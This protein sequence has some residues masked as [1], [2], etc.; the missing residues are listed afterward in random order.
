MNRMNNKFFKVK[1]VALTATIMAF[2]WQV[3]QCFG[4]GN[5]M[6][7]K[8]TLNEWFQGNLKYV[9]KIS[10]FD[11][12]A[13]LDG[14]VKGVG[15]RSIAKAGGASQ[16]PVR[17]VKGDGCL[18]IMLDAQTPA[19]AEVFL[20]FPATLDMT[21]ASS[22]SFAVLAPRRIPNVEQYY[23]TVTASDGS[24]NFSR[25]MIYEPGAWNTLVVNF[26]D[27]PFKNSIRSF[28]FTFGIDSRVAAFW[29]SAAIYLDEVYAGKIFD[30]NFAADG[31]TQGF[32]ASGGTLSARN[33]CLEL[34][35]TGRNASIVSPVSVYNKQFV[36]FYGPPGVRNTIYIVMKN[37]TDARQMTVSF[38]NAHGVYAGHKTI[39]IEPNASDFAL[40]KVNFSEH[41]QWD[42]RIRQFKIAFPAAV[43]AGN[44]LID[45]IS[46]EEDEEIYPYAGKVTSVKYD[47]AQGSISVDGY[48]SESVLKA[49]TGGKIAFYALYLNDADESVQTAKPLHTVDLSTLSATAGKAGFSVG[50]IKF[51]KDA[52]KTYLDADVLAVVE[53]GDRFFKIDKRQAVDNWREL[54]DGKYMFDNPSTVFDVA[55]YGAKGDGFT[56][57]TDAIQDAVDAAWSAGGGKVLLGGGKTY[58]ATNVLLKD[59]ITLFIEKGSVLRRSSDL[60]HY[61][62]PLEFGHFSKMFSHIDFA[63]SELIFNLPLVQADG[64]VNVKLTGGGQIRMPDEDNLSDSFLSRSENPEL[65]RNEVAYQFPVCAQR[66]HTAPIGFFDVKGCEISDIEIVRCSGYH[67][68]TYFC[69]NITIANVRM[70]EV[71]CIGSDGISLIGAQ[72]AVIFAVKFMSNDDGIVLCASF[73]EPRGIFWF[74]SMPGR[75][76]S[77]RNVEVYSSYI[78]ASAAGRAIAFIPWGSNAPDLEKTIIQGITVKDCTLAAEYAAKGFR[79]RPS[80]ASAGSVGAWADNPYNG[81]YP[82]DN[83]ETDDY[84]CIQD[85][86]ILNNVYLS[87]CSI[88]PAIVTN[89]I[90]DCGIKSETDFVNRD[91]TDGLNYWSRT[92]KVRVTQ[93]GQVKTAEIKPSDG[94]AELFQGLH[95]E[96]GAYLFSFNVKAPEGFSL[97]VRD[98]LTGVMVSEIPIN[99]TEYQTENINAVI[100]TAGTYH[101]GIRTE[102]SLGVAYF[103]SP[104]M[105]HEK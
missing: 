71:R 87:R 59:N 64:A 27:C 13:T 79:D 18:E 23:V 99:A 98:P 74:H 49:N 31:D 83:R 7:P 84:S 20:N 45:R 3:H 9:E 103:N 25:K 68:S 24:E 42:D 34:A 4:Q 36:A 62:Y 50:G 70:H 38:S 85:V 17:P 48:I 78:A 101:I 21:A 82:F 33:D 61:K 72:N 69:K 47:R 14:W 55:E 11:G 86:T 73:H 95:L 1:T 15:V 81:R 43:R 26:E 39:D 89:C 51:M 80:Q 60:R 96:P 16:T 37:A 2:C 46:F 5:N 6:Y 54:I 35:I 88:Y 90:T 94:M 75:D 41:P 29:Q 57:D 67:I 63:S 53:N 19:L 44:V 92:G 76:Q 93:S 66:L 97:F 91:F 10:D 12:A 8:I 100:T 32:T 77:V 56:D 58:I 22:L 104:S 105:N 40:Y 102:R 28:Q 30:M 65:L 52:T